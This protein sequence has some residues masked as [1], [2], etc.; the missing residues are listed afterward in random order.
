MHVPVWVPVHA[1]AHSHY[2]SPCLA[3]LPRTA[4]RQ[5]VF[6]Y[7]GLWNVRVT[8]AQYSAVTSPSHRTRRSPCLLG[9]RVCGGS[10][11]H[12]LPGMSMCM[13]LPLCGCTCVPPVMTCVYRCVRELRSRV[14]YLGT[15]LASTCDEHPNHHMFRC[16]ATCTDMC[17][18]PSCAVTVRA[19]GSCTKYNVCARVTCGSGLCSC[20]VH[21]ACCWPRSPCLA[22]RFW[23]CGI[24]S[25]MMNL[26]PFGG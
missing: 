15:M 18:L 6:L 12:V 22:S 26:K 20:C 8:C 17:M 7:Y 16:C 10:S 4:A 19:Y 3:M 23:V 13:A 21:R 14:L 11:P 2:C 9:F 24:K 1:T 5:I 25:L